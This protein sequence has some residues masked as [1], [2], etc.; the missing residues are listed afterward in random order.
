MLESSE[1][2]KEAMPHWTKLQLGLRDVTTQCSGN[3]EYYADKSI[4]VSALEAEVMCHGCPL[5]KP[6]YD[7]A[8]ADNISAGIW[9][10]LHFDEDDGSIF[11]EE[12]F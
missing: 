6:C 5:I 3:P 12:D 9:G 4:E 1:I 11:K 2:S 7:Y 10:G 8:V